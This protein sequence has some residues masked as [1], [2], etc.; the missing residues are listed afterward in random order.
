M[1]PLFSCSTKAFIVSLLQIQPIQNGFIMK[2]STY[3]TNS[4]SSFEFFPVSDGDE[5][6][7][8][9]LIKN[10]PHQMSYNI[11]RQ[12]TST[13]RNLTSIE[14]NFLNNNRKPSSSIR[15]ALLILLHGENGIDKAHELILGVN[16]TNIDRAEYAAKNHGKTSWSID[17]PLDAY[18]TLLHAIIHRLEGSYVGEGGYTGYE[19][20]KYW[21]WKAIS[22]D[23][24]SKKIK[25][26]EEILGGF[27][28][29]NK[30]HCLSLI[31]NTTER[32]YDIIAGGKQKRKVYVRSGE[33][34]YFRFV[35]LCALREKAKH[36]KDFEDEDWR[37]EWGHLVDA[38][39]ELELHLLLHL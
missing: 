25:R 12:G 3:A 35:D 20:S 24:S 30:Y 4:S 14:Q 8:H 13:I 27:V 17:H 26:Y 32:T 2:N 22:G 33:F 36:I 21:Y 16:I 1:A 11:S 7:V 9:N 34:D 29:T 38:I 19:N 18:Q 10:A 5:D 28:R 37:I 31:C 15:G 23:Q 6:S 39:Q